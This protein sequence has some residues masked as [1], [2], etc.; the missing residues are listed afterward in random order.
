[1]GLGQGH[2]AKKLTQISV[3]PDNSSPIVSKHCVFQWQFNVPNG[4]MR[5][6]ITADMK[7]E[8][9]L[10]RGAGIAAAFHFDIDV[11]SIP[12]PVHAACRVEIAAH[13]AG[14]IG[15]AVRADLKTQGLVATRRNVFQDN[16]LGSGF[17]RIHQVITF[18]FCEN[19][20]FS[21]QLYRT[22]IESARVH[23]QTIAR[24]GAVQLIA[25]HKGP[26]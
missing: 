20:V 16:D 8:S 7:L 14:D 4:L 19:T 2:P 1:M 12:G 17:F 23:I 3:D 18:F 11:A 26:T 9:M 10:S 6:H 21:L 15:Q 24:R 25:K 22:E 13:R 5:W